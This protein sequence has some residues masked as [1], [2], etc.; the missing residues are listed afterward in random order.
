[1]KELSPQTKTLIQK[2]QQYFFSKEKETGST[3]HVDEV[4]SKVASFYEKIKELINWQEEHL[5]RKS[6]IERALK[7][8][9]LLKKEGKEI[10]EPLVYE[11]IRGGYFPNDSIPERKIEVVQKLIDKY[12]FLLNN[13]PPQKNNNS[14]SLNDWIVKIMACELEELL[15]PPEREKALI[16]YMI[17]TL[18]ER[19]EIKDERFKN[20]S[21]EEKETILSVAVERA[22]FGFDDYLIA[23]HLLQRW[24][25]EWE[26]PSPSHLRTISQNIFSIREKITSILSH[27]LE[28]EFFKIC[29]RYDTPYLIVGDIINSSPYQ[30]K[31]NLENPQILEI[32][33]K[34]AYQKRLKRVKEK[35]ER[36][37]T[38]STISIFLSK[39]LV[40]FA[41]E[42]PF[43]KYITHQFDYFTLIM[44]IFIPVF[45]MFLLILTIKPPSE[46]NL[47]MVI[48]EVM[49]IV[50]QT[51][52]KDIYEVKLPQKR[53]VALNTVIGVLYG[54]SFIFT[55]GIIIW[56]LKKLNFS[57]LSILIFLIFTSLI[58]FAG[59]KTRQQAKE[60]IVEK[61]KETFFQT[62][63]DAFSLP[64]IHLGKWLSAQWAKF[65]ILVLFFNLLLDVPFQVFV[66]FL[67]Q[68]RVF[69]KKK[70]EEIR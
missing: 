45:L 50:Y 51:Q 31:K 14:F 4:A 44:N 70:K 11:L 8:R 67:E 3:I 41:I 60:L 20:I 65:N 23:Y 48:M 46:R 36:A 18:K 47:E 21:E 27:P 12:V 38:Y 53:S 55:F 5:L 61:E 42:V 35:M 64:L 68:W 40:A 33:I 63:I 54:L 57:P 30:A 62:F 22:L 24:F 19:I 37:A 6:A 59:V 17:E 69:L 29:E 10:A 7:R 39:M 28:K 13:L 16:E 66:E 15:S 43:D 2:Y 25:P 26:D 32:K 56:G 49:K 1:M 58:S 52:K 34:Q 9:L